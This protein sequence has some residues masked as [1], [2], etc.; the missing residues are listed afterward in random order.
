MKTLYLAVAVV[1]IAGAALPAPPAEQ[2]PVTKGELN[3]TDVLVAECTLGDLLADAVLAAGKADAALVNAS[4]LKTPYTIPAGPIKPKQL[5]EA[6][7]YPEDRVVV[8]T[9]KGDQLQQALERAV[10]LSPQ[11]NKAFLQVAGLDFS[12]SSSKPAGQPRVLA[13]IV[14]GQPLDRAKAYR[15]AM[16]EPLAKGGLGYFP[17][18]KGATAQ[19]SDLSTLAALTSYAQQAK[20]LDTKLEGRIRDLAHPEQ[21]TAT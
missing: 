12:Y 3:T 21:E 17:I 13:V 15:V 6:L 20:V 4:A 11:K 2:Y 10:A 16:P 1:A 14:G 8:L 19:K 18:F 9:L 5:A 7:P